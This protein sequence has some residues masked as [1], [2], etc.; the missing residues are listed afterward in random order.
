[1]ATAT[2]ENKKG[3]GMSRPV[4]ITTEY[5]GVF[6]GYA[7][8]TSGDD[9]VLTNCRNCI[10]WPSTQGG[11]LGLASIGPV[12]GSR[13]GERVS[14]FEARKVTGVAEVSAEA[15]AAWEGADVYRG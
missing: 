9:V 7:E 8:D 5:K 10:Y 12:D 11:F 1:M 14:Q 4:L 15:V 13:I 3:K 2:A 6:F